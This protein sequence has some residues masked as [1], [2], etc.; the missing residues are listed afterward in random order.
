MLTTDCKVK[1]LGFGSPLMDLIA[2]VSEE[3]IEKHKLIL[4]QT[5]HK[6][7]SETEIFSILEN[8]T[9]VTYVPGGCSYNTMRIFNVLHYVN[10]ALR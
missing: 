8:E 2:D 5:I 1:Y 9:K 7:M 3:L 4:D 10:L 6:K